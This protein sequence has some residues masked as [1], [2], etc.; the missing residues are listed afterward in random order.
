M[1]EPQPAGTRH[2]EHQAQQSECDD[3]L[4]AGVIYAALAGMAGRGARSA[5]LPGFGW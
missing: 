4:G 2:V 1:V 3:K 5:I